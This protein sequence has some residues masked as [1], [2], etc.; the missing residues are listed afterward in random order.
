MFSESAASP[1]LKTRLQA[2]V[3]DT[4]KNDAASQ[5]KED[6]AADAKLKSIENKPLAIAGKQMDGKDFTTADWKG[7]LV[8]VDFWATW[9]G[10]CVA[11]LPRVKKI[12]ADYH[13]K[14]IGD[15]GV[16]NDDRRAVA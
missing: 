15:S 14:G 12:Y 11:E 2:L 10:P 6:I 9:C 13:D 1:D 3:T 4:M 8:L 5:M 16:S 7:K